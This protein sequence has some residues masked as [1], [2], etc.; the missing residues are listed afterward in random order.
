MIKVNVSKGF[1]IKLPN[2]VTKQLNIHEGESL[3]LDVFSKNTLILS[4]ILE[5]R[6]K[7]ADEAFGMWQERKDISD[8]VQYVND[9]REEWQ[10]G[11]KKND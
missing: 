8:E 10:P 7:L 3:L 4:R 11:T 9:V 1:T 5:E 2:E 6:E